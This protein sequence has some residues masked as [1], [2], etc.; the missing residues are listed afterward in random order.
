VSDLVLGKPKVGLK[1]RDGGLDATITLEPAAVSINL[2]FILHLS[3]SFGGNVLGTLD[4]STTTTSKITINQ[5]GVTVG[6]DIEKLPGKE[7]TVE[8]KNFKLVMKDIQL[9]PIQNLV[10]DLGS[11]KVPPPLDLVLGKEIKLGKY[12]LSQLVGPLND[13]IANNVLDPLLN[14]ITQPLMNLLEPFVTGLMGDAI[15]QLIGLLALHQ[16]IDI[17]PLLGGESVPL[18]FAT[19]ISSIV[20][21]TT[22]GR[23]GL[24]AGVLT[25]KKVDREPLGS[26]LR[27][28]CAHQDPE[29]VL[30]EFTP[31]PS[32]Q[33]GVRY[34]LV[35]ELLFMVWW[36]G[37]T[38]QKFDLSSVVPPDLPISD[39]VVTPNLLLPPILDDCNSKGMQQLQV[40]GAYLDVTFV[41]LGMDQHLGI[42]LQA[43]ATAGIIGKGN[44]IGI[45]IDKV[46]TFETE[47]TD[48]G[49][50]MGDLMGMIDGLVPTL[51]GQI[52]GREFTFPI[53]AIDIGTII[54]G[55]PAGTKI[56]LGNLNAFNKKGVAV[57]GGDLQ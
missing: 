33:L 27:D 53:P 6:F 26:I 37:I 35:N 3:A 52:E 14:L 7:L 55:L 22:G 40:A 8:G 44:E 23:V 11:I 56:Q 36:A 39:V 57:I 10:I 15:Q 50:N 46:N 16:T 19:Q 2:S 18:E 21:K 12:D 49:G 32:I 9:D 45:R 41:L 30:F 28:Q 4:P 20:F 1:C 54:P 47:I 24:K 34:D 5:L 25:A 42:W 43:R 13:L 17:P 31:P 48:I 29:P 51:L 38:N